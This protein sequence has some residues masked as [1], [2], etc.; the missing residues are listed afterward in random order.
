MVWRM[1]GTDGVWDVSVK[2]PSQEQ[3]Q[4]LETMDAKVIRDVVH[5]LF[6]VE[7]SFDVR[8]HAERERNPLF[9]CH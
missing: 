5:E 4:R 1:V 2:Q 7:L 6:V 3:Q 9:L 8:L